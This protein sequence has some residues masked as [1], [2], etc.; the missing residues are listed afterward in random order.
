[1]G[2]STLPL[3]LLSAPH[4]RPR[5]IVAVVVDRGRLDNAG[6]EVDGDVAVDVYVVAHELAVDGR[7]AAVFDVAVHGPAG[8]PVDGVDQSV[9][10]RI[11][12]E[13]DSAG[14][15]YHNP[16]RLRRVRRDGDG[17]CSAAE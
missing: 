17:C 7:V 11:P 5:V 15:G 4:L 8:V 3:Y 16:R 14:R 2:S 10:A 9:Q 12:A 6:D 13:I 1:M